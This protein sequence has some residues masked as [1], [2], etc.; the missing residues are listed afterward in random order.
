MKTLS[1]KAFANAVERKGWTLLRVAGSHYIYGKDG[2]VARL[3][4]PIHGKRALKQG[5]QRSLMTIAKM[6]ESDL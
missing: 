3:S 5:L 1:G 4:I 2:E 6:H